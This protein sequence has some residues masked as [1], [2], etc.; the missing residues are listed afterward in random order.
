MPQAAECTF[1]VLTVRFKQEGGQ[2]TALCVELG[3]AACADSLDE[4][5][6]AITELIGLHLNTL[7]DVGER[8]AFFKK[9]GIKT[10]KGTLRRK[11]D[12][13]RVAPGELVERL[14]QPVPAAA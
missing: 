9:H 12:P 6:D 10:H 7:E 5:R 4:C 8:E 14:E 1:V 2:W 11:P 13:V 3:T